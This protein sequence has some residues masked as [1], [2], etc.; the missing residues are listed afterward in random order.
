VLGAR[1]GDGHAAVRQLGK[2]AVVE[3]NGGAEGPT[4]EFFKF[5]ASS[6]LRNGAGRFT[7]AMSAQGNGRLKLKLELPIAD[8]AASRVSGEYEFADNQVTL[9]RDLPPLEA[10]RGR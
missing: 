5:L 2:A 6:P 1:V 7:A 8:L 4:A 3:V 10:A 9:H